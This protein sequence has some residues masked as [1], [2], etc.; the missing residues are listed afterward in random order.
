MKRQDIPTSQAQVKALLEEVRKQGIA[1]VCD[2]L[3]PGVVGFCAPVF[4]ANQ[5]LA[6]GI[7]SLGPAH[8]FDANYQGLPARVLREAASSLSRELGHRPHSH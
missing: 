1:R 8:S 2:T 6:L 3:L 7:I 5:H 4:D